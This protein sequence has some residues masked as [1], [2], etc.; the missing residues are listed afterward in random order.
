MNEMAWGR[1]K[2]WAASYDLSIH[3]I[4]ALP[5]P[6]REEK[7][8]VVILVQGKEGEEHTN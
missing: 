8:R 1:V 3:A 2:S 4:N 6:R 7:F 5:G